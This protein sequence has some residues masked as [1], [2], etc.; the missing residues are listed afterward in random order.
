MDRRASYDDARGMGEGILDNR[1]TQHRYWLLFE[2]RSKSASS[3]APESVS[4]P[5][6]LAN[7]M[8]RRLNFPP[9]QFVCSDNNVKDL[10]RSQARGLERPLSEAV[11]L[12]NLRT[13]T[14]TASGEKPV[15]SA[16]L[17]LH[18]QGADCQF[19]NQI[20][21]S[22]NSGLFLPS[23]NGLKISSVELMSLTGNEV[24]K[25]TTN[26]DKNNYENEFYNDET[27]RDVKKKNLTL[28]SLNKNWTFEAMRLQTLRLKF[29]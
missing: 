10:L 17:I 25:N 29:D 8:G 28:D 13:L 5:T 21:F 22:D 6:Q 27:I 23:F 4:L 19:G 9:I 26:G 3:S 14:S 7:Q 15:N 11:H 16:L 12:F 24:F 18:R 1:D 20:E 2:T